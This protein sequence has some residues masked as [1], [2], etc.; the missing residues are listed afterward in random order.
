MCSRL[1][2]LND[3]CVDYFQKEG[4]EL[5]KLLEEDLFSPQLVCFRSGM[6]RGNQLESQ[7]EQ[8]FL[9][10][11]ARNPSNC[12]LCKMVILEVKSMIGNKKTQTEVIDF[13][14]KNLCEK[15]GENK[16]KVKF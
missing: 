7:S 4:P 11:D 3:T 12:T 5:F 6:C 14:N 13:I 2:Q 8:A 10:L 16:E 9:D 15:V 1:G